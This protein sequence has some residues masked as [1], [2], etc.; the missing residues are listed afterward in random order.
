MKLAD[1]THPAK[2]SVMEISSTSTP[3]IAGR[4]SNG[5]SVTMPTAE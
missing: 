4:T 1:A 5:I 3:T 2:D